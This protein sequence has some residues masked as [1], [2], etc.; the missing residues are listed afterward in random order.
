VGD[1]RCGW[2]F[3][4]L[5]CWRI[6]SRLDFFVVETAQSIHRL[7]VTPDRGTRNP[8]ATN[9]EFASLAFDLPSGIRGAGIP[10]ACHRADQRLS[11]D[12]LFH[13]H[14]LLNA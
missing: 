6:E 8:Y 1:P 7:R 9:G 12:A 3:F 5:E 13:L 11:K 2:R 14:Q 10:H 4:L